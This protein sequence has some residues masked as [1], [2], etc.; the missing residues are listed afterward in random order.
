MASRDRGRARFA[1]HDDDLQRVELDGTSLR[2]QH[3]V[4]GGKAE[5][6]A[7]SMLSNQ[8]AHGMEISFLAGRRQH[9]VAAGE[10]SPEDPGDR[11]VER[12]GGQQQ[13][14]VGGTASSGRGALRRPGRVGR[15]VGCASVVPLPRDESTPPGSG[16]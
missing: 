12:E 15:D 10:Q 5:C 4:E 14:A 13:E 2:E 3:L 8:P 11:A 6:V 16:S 1:G 7:D 9:Q